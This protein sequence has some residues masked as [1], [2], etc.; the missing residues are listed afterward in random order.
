MMK[1]VSELILKNLMLVASLIKIILKMAA[2]AT[3]K[4]E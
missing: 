2:T 4:Y 1:L 3:T